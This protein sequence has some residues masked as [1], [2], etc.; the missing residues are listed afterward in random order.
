MHLQSTPAPSADAACEASGDVAYYRG[1][2]HELIDMGMDLARRVHARGVGA[3]EV[4]SDAAV[5]PAPGAAREVSVAFE[6]IARTVRRTV[7]LAR[8]LDEPVVARAELELERRRVAVRR[9]IIRRVEDAIFRERLDPVAAERLRDDMFE[10]LDGPDVDDDALH[11]PVD[12]IIREICDD[13]GIGIPPGG[14]PW[15]PRSAAEVAEI[16]ARAAGVR[17]A[18]ADAATAEGLA[19]EGGGR[20]N[21]VEWPGAAKARETAA[22]VEGPAG[23]ERG[24]PAGDEDLVRM[25]MGGRLAGD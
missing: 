9:R 4:G 18:D 11:R 8:R 2:L 6:R 13:L 15:K 3:A 16:H 20:G 12:E 24:A 17:R 14:T 25:L 10:R 7:G 22:A 19:A 23:C 1:V 5:E 21:L